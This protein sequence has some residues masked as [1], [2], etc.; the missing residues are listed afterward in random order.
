MGSVCE[1]G[2]EGERRW[3][4]RERHVWDAVEK[5]KTCIHVNM[6]RMSLILC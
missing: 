1:S 6:T 5:D 2:I 4:R 3:Q